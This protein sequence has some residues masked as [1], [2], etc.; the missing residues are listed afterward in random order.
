MVQPYPKRIA[1]CIANDAGSMRLRP[2]ATE[3]ALLD[4][5]F[6]VVPCTS[7][8]EHENR[9]GRAND[10]H[11]D[12]VESQCPRPHKEANGNGESHSNKRR[13]DHLP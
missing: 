4:I 8:V 12:Q 9:Q 10:L 7:S 5:L 1:K 2:L 13:R 6:G 3:V 11:P